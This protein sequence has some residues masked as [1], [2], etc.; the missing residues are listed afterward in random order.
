MENNNDLLVSSEKGVLTIRV[1]RPKK[2]NAM[3]SK[4]LKQT[5]E[6]MEKAKS[7]DTIKVIFFTA[8]GNEVFTSGNDFN[9]FAERTF[10]EMIADFEGFIKYLIEYPKVM[11]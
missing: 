6:A 10:D 5:V 1:N 4:M 2:K 8:S 9:N 11:V 3:T 7:D